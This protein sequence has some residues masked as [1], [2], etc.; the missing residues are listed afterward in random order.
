MKDINIIELFSG[1]GMQRRGFENSGV[2]NTN[3]VATSEIASQAIITYAAMHHGMTEEWLDAQIDLPSEEMAQYL[4][5][6]N[7][8]WDYKT[9]EP[10]NWSTYKKGKKYRYLKKTYYACQ[11]QNNLGDISRVD[12]LPKVDLWFYSFPCTDISN[13]GT[14]KGLK[15]GSGTRSGLLW[16]VERLLEKAVKEGTAPTYLCLENV[17]A[18][19]EARCLADFELWLKRL[20]E[21]GYN[22]YWDKMNSRDYNVPQNRPRVFAMSIKK[23]VDTKKYTF[24]KTMKLKRVLADILDNTF[25]D[26]YYL[27]DTIQNRFQITTNKETDNI[28]GTTKPEFRTIGQRDNVYKMESDYI[29]AL[30]ATDYKQPKQI[31]NIPFCP[32]VIQCENF[33]D[34]KYTIQDYVKDLGTNPIR[35]TVT[36]CIAQNKLI[37]KL[38]PK[39][40]YLL[41]GLTIEDWSK[42]VAISMSDT[43]MYEMTGN[44]IVTDC[45]K[46]LAQHLY[47]AQEDSNFICDDE[48]TI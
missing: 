6:K 42:S 9:K 21:L 37:R 2:Y 10:K 44:G 24:P 47:Q 38:T 7:I 4:L 22:T 36:D 34:T 16:E 5:D 29:G 18:L 30:V 31:L 14:Q 46:L 40:C 8:D 13:S 28:I 27:S 12:K 45:V 33:A 1:I 32:S 35:G 11:L 43:A 20:D 25:E 17:K 23:D 3:I 39:E 19:V 41:M 15:K 48:K 26:N